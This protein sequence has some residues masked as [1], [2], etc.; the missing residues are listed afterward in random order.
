MVVVVWWYE[1]ALGW[2]AIING[3]VK[4]A[5]YQKILNENI[6]PSDRAQNLEQQVKKHTRKF[7]SEWLKKQNE[8]FVWPSES[9]D[10]K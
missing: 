8:G 2:L 4:S 10:L 5:L 6:Y 3:T 1:A 7:T 9:L